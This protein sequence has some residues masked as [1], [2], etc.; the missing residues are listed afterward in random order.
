MGIFLFQSLVWHSFRYN[1]PP[2][3]LHFPVDGDKFILTVFSCVTFCCMQMPFLWKN[4]RQIALLVLFF[5]FPCWMAFLFT[6]SSQQSYE[7]H[8]GF[9][10]NLL[11]FF[12][13]TVGQGFHSSLWEL[14]IILSKLAVLSGCSSQRDQQ[15]CISDSQLLLQGHPSHISFASSWHSRSNDMLALTLQW[16]LTSS[17]SQGQA[18]LGWAAQTEKP[19]C[20]PLLGLWNDGAVTSAGG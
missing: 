14:P 5:F 17:A 7:E 12:L 4:K 20:L 15:I 2:L 1:F 10:D 3:F 16:Y 18:V 8:R 9:S 19:A 6:S 13:T 11:F